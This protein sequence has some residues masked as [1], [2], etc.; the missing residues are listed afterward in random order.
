[1][2]TDPTFRDVAIASKL[3]AAHQG[4]GNADAIEAVSFA[5]ADARMRERAQIVA[6]LRE[7]TAL[8]NSLGSHYANEIERGC[9]RD[10]G[11]KL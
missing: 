2:S 11:P 5:I 1:M 4:V 6:Y 9:H 7:T 3:V 10:D 8:P